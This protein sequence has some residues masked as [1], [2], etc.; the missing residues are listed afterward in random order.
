MQPV[1]FGG[2]ELFQRK[3]EKLAGGAVIHWDDKAFRAKLYDA[4]SKVNKRGALRL[5]RKARSIVRMRAYD[6]GALMNSIEVYRSKY[7]SMAAFGRDHK[8]STDWIISAG[9]DTA[10][11][12]GHV[13]LGRYFQDTGTRVPAVPFM[14]Q[15]AADTRKWMR[16]RMKSALRA[17]IK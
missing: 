17:A 15:A 14:R 13:E 11:Y 6:T 2:S 16:P 7:Q 3:I 9:G 10:S 4:I 5:K 1:M 8:V 12:V